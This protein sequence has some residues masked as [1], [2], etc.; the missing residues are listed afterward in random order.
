MTETNKM[1]A[2]ALMDSRELN[3]YP[4]SVSREEYRRRFET[5]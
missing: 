1:E 4:R 5:E 3:E 2:Q